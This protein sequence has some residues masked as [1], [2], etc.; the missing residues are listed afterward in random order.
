MAKTTKEVVTTQRSAA[1]LATKRGGVADAMRIVA[2]QLTE[3]A[4]NP[5]LNT[6]TAD[7]I[8]ALE[9]AA[10]AFSLLKEEIEASPES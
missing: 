5:A 6:I 3:L 8:A 1:W 9:S 4:A 2:G 7:Q 10:D